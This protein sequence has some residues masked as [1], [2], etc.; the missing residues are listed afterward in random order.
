MLGAYTR[1]DK[2]EI[3]KDLQFVYDKFPILFEKKD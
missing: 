1:N 2:A 3:A